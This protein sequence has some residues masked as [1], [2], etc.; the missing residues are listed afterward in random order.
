MRKME[1]RQI[2][3]G[4]KVVEIKPFNEGEEWGVGLRRLMLAQPLNAIQSQGFS[5]LP[6]REDDE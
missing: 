3:C 5:V 2:D 1:D 6:R 4:K